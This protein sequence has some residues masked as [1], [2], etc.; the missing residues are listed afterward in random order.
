MKARECTSQNGGKPHEDRGMHVG[1][2]TGHMKSRGG[3]LGEGG[4]PHGGR[5]GRGGHLG[6]GVGLIC[7]KHV[8]GGLAGQPCAIPPFRLR[9]PSIS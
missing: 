5:G 9:S 1:K 4:K 7:S 6:E 2:E 8:D 3:H